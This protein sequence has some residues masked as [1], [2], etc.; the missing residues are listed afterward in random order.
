MYEELK[1]KYIKFD[2]MVFRIKY[3]QTKSLF[4]KIYSAILR[5]IIKNKGL[6]IFFLVVLLYIITGNLLINTISGAILYL[7]ILANRLLNHKMKKDRLDM[8]NLDDFMEYCRIDGKKN[9]LDIYI[10]DIFAR[11]IILNE[12]SINNMYINEKLEKTM[13]TSLL[14]QCA[15][16]MSKD[17]RDKLILYYGTEAF[18]NIL[19]EKCYI[20]VSLYAA[21]IN[22]QLYAKSPD[23]KEFF[24]QQNW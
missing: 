14:D 7:M 17:L 15:R 8:I 23:I 4:I 3:L 1:E 19:T 24:N 22:K 12:G 2:T 21:N 20:K 6:S 11:Y 10:D 18:P 13:L 5:R 16:N 9:I